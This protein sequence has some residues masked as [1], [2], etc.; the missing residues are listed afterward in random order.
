MMRFFSIVAAACV[1][2]E[3][4]AR[5]QDARHP[6]AARRDDAIAAIRATEPDYADPATRRLEVLTEVW[7]NIGLYHPVP[8]AMHLKWDDVLIA[9]LHAL[10]EVRSDRDLVDVLNRIVFAPLHDPLTYALVQAER[11]PPVDN[12]TRLAARWLDSST[13]YIMA[14]DQL[15]MKE[16]ATPVRALID[17]LARAHRIDR[18]V[19]DLRSTTPSAYYLNMAWLGLWV[20]DAVAHGPDVSVFRT[21]EDFLGGV[22]WLVSPRDSLRP[23]APEITVP[24]VFVVNRTEYMAAERALDAVRSRRTD[25]AVV[26]EDTG[27]IPIM[28]DRSAQAWYPDSI[29]LSHTRSPIISA[30][31]ALG[32]MVDVEISRAI[33]ANELASIAGR[34]L[35]I[36][37]AQPPRVAFSLAQAG[38]VDDTVSSGP[39]TP[40]QRLAGL[41]KTWFWVLHFYAYPE[42]VAGDWRRLLSKFVPEVQA[43]TSDT[44]YYRVLLR[45]VDLLNDTHVDVTHPLAD[46]PARMSRLFTAPLALQWI[47]RRLAVFRVDSSAAGIGVA[48]GDEVLAVDGRTVPDLTAAANPFWSRS[49]PSLNP[50]PWALSG[51]ARDVPVTLRVRSA[52]GVHDVR[53]PSSRFWRSVYAAPFFAHPAYAILPGNLGFIDLGQMT[54]AQQFDSAMTAL[55]NTDGILLDERSLASYNA[56]VAVLRFLDRVIPDMRQMESM[57]Y[58]L[59]SEAPMHAQG[60]IKRWIVPAP[61]KGMQLYTKPLVVMTSAFDVSWGESLAQTL[62]IA[63]RATL[64]GS[65]TNGTFG[66]KD[67][68]TIPG[69]AIVHFTR[70]RALWPDGSKYHGIGVVPDVRVEPTFHGLRQGRDEVYDAALSTLR[71]LVEQ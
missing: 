69:G 44:A 58:M 15:G 63:H 1:L 33:A 22:N 46:G 17:S 29:L 35:A 8:S 6:A 18:L 57:T 56:Q 53:L 24:T 38:I 20:R 32:A 7:G 41:L 43:A 62:R 65:P 5:A 28:D 64:V 10:P 47:G 45:M 23:I 59:H 21:T 26:L 14:F 52:S 36:R 51:R 19:I 37:R 9:A 67:G 55:R 49:Q 42:D 60:S 12:S 48:V 34:A 27:P 66:P 54:S 68:I 4:P 11:Y 61:S 31:G 71:R 30:D 39:L 3:M 2:A 70:G 40:E 50:P 16:F 13:A 25:V